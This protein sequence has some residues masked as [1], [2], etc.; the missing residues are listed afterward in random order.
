[1]RVS[2]QH[3]ITFIE[4]CNEDMVLIPLTTWHKLTNIRL[5]YVTR[6]AEA[7]HIEPTYEERL[8][9]TRKKMLPNPDF[10]EKLK[11]HL[12]GMGITTPGAMLAE[13]RRRSGIRFTVGTARLWLKGTFKPRLRARNA[14]RDH[15]G[16]DY[17]YD[18]WPEA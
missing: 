7:M 18:S 14:L 9:A 16:F 17:D 13:L 1:M 10:A 5:I 8:E 4:G 6:H 12:E 3:A 2:K 15:L 11:A